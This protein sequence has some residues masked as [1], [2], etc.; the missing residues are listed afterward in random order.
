M[1]LFNQIQGQKIICESVCLCWDCCE[2]NRCEQIHVHKHNNSNLKHHQI[3]YHSGYVSPERT[4][5]E[6]LQLWLMALGGTVRVSWMHKWRRGARLRQIRRGKPT[7]TNTI[8]L[9]QNWYIHTY[10]L[11][12]TNKL[13]KQQLPLLVLRQLRT[14]KVFLTGFPSLPH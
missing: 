8:R 2:Q 5:T 13:F 7:S 9:R 14:S 6:Q 3:V 1:K 4:N 11:S 10:I 12:S